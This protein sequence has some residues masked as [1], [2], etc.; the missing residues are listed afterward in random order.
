MGRLADSRGLGRREL[1]DK[2]ILGKKGREKDRGPA[3]L[4]TPEEK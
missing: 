3:L 4:P 2:N 1:G